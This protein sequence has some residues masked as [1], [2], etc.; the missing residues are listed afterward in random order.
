MLAPYA[1]Y[2]RKVAIMRTASVRI[3][4]GVLFS[5]VN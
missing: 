1:P 2:R 3:N 4:S 5:T